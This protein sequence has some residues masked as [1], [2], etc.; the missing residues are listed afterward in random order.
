VTPPTSLYAKV[1]A[2]VPRGARG[3]CHITGPQG[4]QCHS[5][6]IQKLM[7]MGADVMCHCPVPARRASPAMFL[8]AGMINMAG[9]TATWSS[10]MEIKRASAKLHVSLL[11]HHP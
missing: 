11:D 2:C 1:Y 4:V 6:D 5:E 8:V 7:G 9:P 10:I 3:F